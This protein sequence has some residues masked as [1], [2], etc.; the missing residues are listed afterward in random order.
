MVIN[1]GVFNS[2]FYFIFAF[3]NIP[4]VGDRSFL[5]LFYGGPQDHQFNYCHVLPS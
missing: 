3:Y 2:Y 5:V 4:S 1:M